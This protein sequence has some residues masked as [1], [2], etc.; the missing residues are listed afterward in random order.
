M[1]ISWW[2]LE[3]WL[4]WLLDYLENK[5]LRTKVNRAHKSWG[6]STSQGTILDPFMFLVFVRD[7]LD[8][9]S[10]AALI[11]ADDAKICR[12]SKSDS[13]SF[14]LRKN[15]ITVNGHAV[16]SELKLTNQDM[17][18]TLCLI[19]YKAPILS[20]EIRS[21]LSSWSRAC[22][23]GWLRYQV[24]IYGRCSQRKHNSPPCA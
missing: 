6:V 5:M 16:D 24:K 3:R 13:Y 4:S 1:Y 12:Y 21:Q 9:I 19:W 23:I 8:K 22:N 10:S 17:S 11:Y 15:L 2:R 18:R 20:M 7:L 14:E